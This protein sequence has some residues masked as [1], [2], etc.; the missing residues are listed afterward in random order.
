[1][2]RRTLLAGLAGGRAAVGTTTPAHG[3]TRRVLHVRPGGSVQTAVDAVT[4]PGWAV[5]VHPG[6]KREVLTSPRTR[7]S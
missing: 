6:A 3:H 5:V 4:G 2:R 7:R 1:M